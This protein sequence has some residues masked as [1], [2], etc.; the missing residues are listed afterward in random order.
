MG[1]IDGNQVATLEELARK[2]PYR[3]VFATISGAHLYGFPSADSD[4]DM[5]GVHCLRAEQL[6]GLNRSDET[7]EI[8]SIENGMEMDIVS[9]DAGK[10]LQLLLKRNGYVL[11]QLFS[12]LIISTNQWH[13]SLMELAQGC[14]TRNHY[15][16]YRGF[17]FN[18]W[19]LMTRESEP[20]L[21]PLLYF[22]RVVLTGIHLMKSGQIE[23]NLETL[24]EEFRLP[25]ISELIQRKREGR[26]KETLTHKEIEFHTSVHESVLEQLDVAFSE[27]RLP[28][29][30]SQKTWDKLNDWLIQL[31]LDT[32]K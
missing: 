19:S 12:P 29:M 13:T 10:F 7:I 15:H 18:Q 1:N 32:L 24:N 30:P 31:R 4:F 8:D 2:H 17:A 11:E 22:Y 23:A 28:E 6:F 21:K 14:I 5:R 20:R 3:L 25:G 26:E 16:H 27:S 9:H